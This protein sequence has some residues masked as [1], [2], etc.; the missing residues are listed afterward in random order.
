M[1][2]KNSHFIAIP[3]SMC[4]TDN[5]VACSCKKESHDSLLLAAQDDQDTKTSRMFTATNH[6]IDN[7]SLLPKTCVSTR[8]W[9]GHA[10]EMLYWNCDGYDRENRSW[11]V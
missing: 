7:I 5:S 10:H 8:T 3:N 11:S 9:K 2:V 1:N 4:P 6:A